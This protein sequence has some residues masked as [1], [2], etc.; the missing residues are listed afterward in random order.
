MEPFFL[1]WQKGCLHSLEK[2]AKGDS[3]SHGSWQ[4]RAAFDIGSCHFV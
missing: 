1:L 2:C 4:N 3:F